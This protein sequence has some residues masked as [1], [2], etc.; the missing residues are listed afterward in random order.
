MFFARITRTCSMSL[1]LFLFST[2]LWYTYIYIYNNDTNFSSNC[3]VTNQIVIGIDVLWCQLIMMAMGMM[4]CVTFTLFWG[5]FELSRYLFLPIIITYDSK[6]NDI[7][8]NTS[9]WNYLKGLYDFH[10]SGK[11]PFSATMTPK[12]RCEGCC[13][14]NE[15]EDI[16]FFSY[17]RC[18]CVRACV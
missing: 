15:K 14:I 18:V 4:A 7:I 9:A 8:S 17:S 10:G 1:L 6:Y 5:E 2:V 16:A 11:N 3:T 12:G 13:P